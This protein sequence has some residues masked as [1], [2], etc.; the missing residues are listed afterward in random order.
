MKHLDKCKHLCLKL[1]KCTSPKVT[2]ELKHVK[3][4]SNGAPGASCNCLIHA[5]EQV[6]LKDHQRQGWLICTRFEGRR[7]K[8]SCYRKK[9]SRKF[10]NKDICLCFQIVTTILCSFAKTTEENGFNGKAVMCNWSVIL[11]PAVGT[12]VHVHLSVNASFLH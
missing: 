7:V 5:G 4:T 2:V 1:L 12:C 9:Q 6:S 8:L 10:M 11:L 3:L